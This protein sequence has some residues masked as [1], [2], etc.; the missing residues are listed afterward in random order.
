MT[1][2]D[3]HTV[4][5]RDLRH[6]TSEV[7]SR[8]RNG[9]T[10]DVTDRGRLIARIVPVGERTPAQVLER[11]VASGRATLARRPGYR[12]RMRP[13]DDTDKR[14]AP[15]LLPDAWDLLSA[16]SY[17]AIDDE[18]VEAAM[19]EPGRA[20]RSPGAIHLGT[21]RILGPDLDGLATYD[22]RDI[23]LTAAANDA[24][25]VVISPQD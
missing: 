15:V 7:L 5:L 21:A 2:T 16:F 6:H 22:I 1:T 19:D 20:L 4:G 18:I 25:L 12:P 10:I 23:R 11:L 9:E 13:G 3:A 8:V 14:A 24:G 17:I